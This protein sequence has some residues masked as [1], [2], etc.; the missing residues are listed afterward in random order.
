MGYV[1]KMIRIYWFNL[2]QWLNRRLLV[3][4][5]LIEDC[6]RYRDC[7]RNVHDFHVPDWLWVEVIGSPHGVY[8]YDCFCNRADEKFGLKVRMVSSKWNYC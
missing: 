7:G 3:T 6:A 4:Y 5:P 8:C 2:L 1:A